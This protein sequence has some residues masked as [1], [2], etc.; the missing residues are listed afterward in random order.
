MSG[1]WYGGSSEPA[2]DGA[3]VLDE[4]GGAGPGD[5]FPDLSVLFGPDE[6]GVLS[7]V[8]SAAE[9][10]EFSLWGYWSAADVSGVLA[11]GVGLLDGPSGRG[12]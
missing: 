5:E 11:V 9:L 7:G 3:D 1:L 2:S 8:A 10:S 4:P 6:V 12:E